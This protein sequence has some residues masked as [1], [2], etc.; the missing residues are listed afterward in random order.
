MTEQVTDDELKRFEQAVEQQ[1]RGADGPQWHDMQRLV[2]EVRCLRADNER[3]R[4]AALLL[5]R[6]E[7]LTNSRDPMAFLGD[8]E[9]NDYS[10]GLNQFYA[11]FGLH[12]D[13]LP[14]RTEG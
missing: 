2:A 7:S 11:V 6:G 5:A 13:V 9:G 8:H 1:E 3:L 12:V 10:P 14:E 4:T